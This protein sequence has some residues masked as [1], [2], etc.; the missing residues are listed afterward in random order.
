MNENIMMI[1]SEYPVWH[2]VTGTASGRD[3]VG[4]VAAHEDKS[5]LGAKKVISSSDRTP[6]W[7]IA[8]CISFT[9]ALPA[10][11]LPFWSL[12]QLECQNNTNKWPVDTQ[13]FRCC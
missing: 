4:A 6:I 9:S 7:F 12:P 13:C 11:L 3:I 10:S 1:G 8:L 5:I 2:C